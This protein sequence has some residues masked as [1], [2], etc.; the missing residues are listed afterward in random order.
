MIT[1]DTFKLFYEKIIVNQVFLSLASS[2][3]GAIIGGFL[4][5]KQQINLIHIV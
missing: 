1:I 2:F 4:H 3:I 5:I